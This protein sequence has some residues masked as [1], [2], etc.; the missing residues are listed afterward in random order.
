MPR[1]GLGL[2]CLV[3]VVS[4]L[5]PG[6]GALAFPAGANLDDWGV[7]P[8]PYGASDWI[9]DPGIDWIVEDSITNYVGPGYGGQTYDVEALYARVGAAELAFAVVT[10]FPVSGTGGYRPGDVA[11]GFPS[12]PGGYPFGLRTTTEGGMTAGGL[13]RTG[14]GDWETS[15]LWG[16]VAD[17]TRMKG[18]AAY[19]GAVSF[20]YLPQEH[21]LAN[22]SHWIIEAA[23]PAAY[24]GSF[25][26]GAVRLH[27]TMTCG[28]DFLE[29]ETTFPVIPEPSTLAL[30][31]LGLAG[32]ALVAFRRR[33]SPPLA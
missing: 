25:Y 22:G 4:I 2:V 24:F 16:G 1:S 17:P 19:V 23:V 26:G 21:F 11:I 15:G 30:F 8:G 29:L 18:T 28:N 33:R 13:Y 20:T 9:P 32:L 31:G 5:L 27:W 14:P 10:G 12:H 7:H 3:M 6:G